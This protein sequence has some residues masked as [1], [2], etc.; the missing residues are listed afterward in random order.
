MASTSNLRTVVQHT[1]AVYAVVDDD[2][3]DEAPLMAL[4]MTSWLDLDT[5]P[6]KSFKMITS[7][8]GDSTINCEIIGMLNS[9]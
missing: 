7:P 2:G 1:W 9:F 4:N 6:L 5:L 8:R 3:L